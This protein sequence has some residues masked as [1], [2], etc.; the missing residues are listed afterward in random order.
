[1][2]RNIMFELGMMDQTVDQVGVESRARQLAAQL[3][4]SRSTDEHVD[5]ITTHLGQLRDGSHYLVMGRTLQILADT[6]HKALTELETLTGNPTKRGKDMAWI[7][8]TGHSP[9]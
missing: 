3:L 2:T 5:L 7:V 8:A 9:G 4:G 1:M 6:A